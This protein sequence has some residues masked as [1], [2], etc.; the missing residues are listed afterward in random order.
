MLSHSMFSQA[1]HSELKRSL[2]WTWKWNH[3]LNWMLHSTTR[4]GLAL[5]QG[6]KK[7]PLMGQ[8]NNIGIKI[9]TWLS[10]LCQLWMNHFWHQAKQNF[11]R[12]SFSDPFRM[13]RKQP[14]CFQSKLVEPH[15][16]QTK[17]ITTLEVKF[18]THSAR[19]IST[20]MTC[21]LKL[22]V[23]NIAHS[24][25]QIWKCLQTES[26]KEKH[27]IRYGQLQ[28]QPQCWPH[29]TC[30]LLF[31]QETIEKG[32]LLQTWA[33]CQTLSFTLPLIGGS[34]PFSVAPF[35][36]RDL[37]SV[38]SMLLAYMAC[39]WVVSQLGGHDKVLI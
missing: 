27:T 14:L 29:D 19:G 16:T 25:Q 36:Q 10:L 18:R 39:C 22:N 20:K 23:D 12:Q 24:W 2:C 17:T 32:V 35:R 26:G 1:L 33:W 4:S 38:H 11:P 3:G 28:S 9:C 13:N 8:K 37:Y 21:Q 34:L 5:N 15:L 30:A 31:D 6:G 7:P